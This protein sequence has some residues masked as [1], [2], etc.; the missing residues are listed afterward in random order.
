MP[1]HVYEHTNMF[2]FRWLLILTCCYIRLDFM[3]V[4]SRCLYDCMWSCL[5]IHIYIYNDLSLHLS[6]SLYIYTYCDHDGGLY[7]IA[8]ISQIR[9]RSLIK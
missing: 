7:I 5:Y 8:N 4:S 3:T 2:F 1:L 9:I 6:L